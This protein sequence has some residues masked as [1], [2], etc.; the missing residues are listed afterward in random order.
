MITM[1][2]MR[3]ASAAGDVDVPDIG[4]VTIGRSRI[5]ATEETSI[6]K[7]RALLALACLLGCGG[8]DIDFPSSGSGRGGGGPGGSSAGGGLGGAGAGAVVSASVGGSSSSSTAASSGLGGGGAASSSSGPPPDCMFDGDCPPVGNPCMAKAC[9][10]GLCAPQPANEGQACDDGLFCTVNDACVA[11]VCVGTAKV[12]PGAADPCHVA[13]CNEAL[14]VCTVTPANDGAPCGNLLA[15]TATSTCAAGICEGNGPLVYFADDFHDNSKGWTLDAEWQIGPALPSSGQTFGFP[16][17]DAD[18]T[19]TNDNGLAGT[20]IGGNVDQ[21]MHGYYYLTSPAFNGVVGG[22]PVFLNYFRVIN[23]DTAMSW[24][25]EVWDGVSWKLA[26]LLGSAQQQTWTGTYI[27]LTMWKS[28]QMRVR[29]GFDITAS[30]AKKASGLS[31]DDLVV[32]TV[33]CF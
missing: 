10:N 9:L 20:V 18:H 27:D 25:I 12:C 8:G 11:G 1:V 15:C 21:G 31:L 2:Y 29:F 6:M 22:G 5:Q 28:A 19:A 26:S 33:T 17:P 30:N 32:T 4:T 13:T 23:L 24:R 3:E 7:R 14:D 16:D